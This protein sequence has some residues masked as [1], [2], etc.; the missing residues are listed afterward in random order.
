MYHRVYVVNVPIHSISGTHTITEEDLGLAPG[1][2]PPEDLAT[3]GSLITV[4]RKLLAPIE[5]IR[6]RVR[7]RLS[8]TGVKVGMGTV[9]TQP[10]LP[11]LIDELT[12]LKAQFYSAKAALVADLDQNIRD[13]A[14]QHPEY[15]SLLRKHAP[16]VRYVERRLAFDIDTFRFDVPTD[17][18]NSNLLSQTLSRSGNDISKRLMREVIDFVD[19][20]HKV[21]VGVDRLVKHNLGPL[22]DTLLPKIH[23]FQLL[24]RRLSAVSRHLEEFLSDATSAIDARPNGNAYLSGSALAPFAARLNQ[25]RSESGLDSLMSSAGS[26]ATPIV[27]PQGTPQV[28]MDLPKTPSG[29]PLPKRPSTP[30]R[31]DGRRQVVAF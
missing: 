16:D 24:D 30:D 2:L 27:R 28:P 31:S 6:A 21:S 1:T 29:R 3:L 11:Q 25:L 17:D 13:R 14:E 15:A 12:D 23:S 26:S 10:D 22:R 20:V 7:R 8:S 18:P 9:V 5:K 4:D 19:G